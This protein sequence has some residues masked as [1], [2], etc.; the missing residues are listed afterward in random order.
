MV[1]PG[2]RPRTVTPPPEELEE[3]GKE[4][5]EWASK[6][7]E[8][9]EF[10]GHRCRFAQWYSLEKG[11]LDKEWDYMVAKPE[12][13][14]YYEKARVY[15][16]NRFI[17]AGHEG[18]IKEKLAHRF[19]HTYFPETKAEDYQKIEFEAATKAKQNAAY[20][21]EDIKRAQEVIEWITRQQSENKD[22]SK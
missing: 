19:M 17:M 1:H 22:L 10:P 11:I 20:T 14:R 3:L 7:L 15:L 6:P 5:L 13:K 21:E 18:Q 9:G 16:S 8:P 2:G 12:F 4:L